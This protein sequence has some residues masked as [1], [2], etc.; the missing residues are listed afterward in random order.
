MDS[1]YEHMGSKDRDADLAPSEEYRY[2]CFASAVERISRGMKSGLPSIADAGAG[3]GGL[4]LAV[5]RKG[6]KV[7]AIDAAESCLAKFND[8]ANQLGIKRIVSQLET[9]PFDGAAFDIV[10]ASE[11]IE[12]LDDP[13]KAIVE[14]FRITKNGGY[15]IVS[16]P[17]S[18][19]LREVVCPHCLKD[20]IPHG[21]KHSFNPA[22]L[23]KILEKA[24]FTVLDTKIINNMLTAR[25]LKGHKISMKLARI[26][27]AIHPKIKNRG[28]LMMTAKK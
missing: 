5:A 28:W 16:V 2:F 12:H 4:S 21:H 15:L 20:F 18:E 13:E 19:T 14:L 11:A 1:Y 8:E 27:D 6:F 25:L 26:L 9:I 24:G 23:K 7:T 3:R 17:Y 10:M 22:G